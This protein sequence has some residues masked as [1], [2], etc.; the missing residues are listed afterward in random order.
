MLLH[1]W[2]QAQGGNTSIAPILAM[3][4]GESP[5]NM[6]PLLLPGKGENEAE[7]GAVDVVE[8]ICRS[9]EYHLRGAHENEGAF[10]IMG[11]LRVWSVSPL[12]FSF[13]RLLSLD[14]AVL[15]LHSIF[16]LILNQDA[17]HTFKNERLLRWVVRILKMIAKSSGF[18]VAKRMVSVVP[19]TPAGAGDGL[20][21]G[22]HT[23]PR[24]EKVAQAEKKVDGPTDVHLKE[25]CCCQTSPTQTT[26]LS[27]HEQFWGAHN[28]KS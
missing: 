8:E 11:P 20:V 26:S 22:L 21:K 12:C 15:I 17:M 28:A 18:S 25:H 19:M 13:H 4:E 10:F 27:C 14:A 23:D 2:K 24:V 1:L 16:T 6:N 7:F 9:I 3:L 5:K